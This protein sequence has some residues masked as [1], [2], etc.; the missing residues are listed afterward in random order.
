MSASHHWHHDDFLFE[1]EMKKLSQ[2]EMMELAKRIAKHE[3]PGM[4]R[5]V[6]Q[7]LLAKTAD[8]LLRVSKDVLLALPASDE[9]N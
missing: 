9:V 5:K 3:A 1:E 6:D 8:R 7:K 4:H 2:S